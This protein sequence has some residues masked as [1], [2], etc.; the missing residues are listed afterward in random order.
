MALMGLSRVIAADPAAGRRWAAEPL[1][2]TERL[3]AVIA[4]LYGTLLESAQEA[5][6]LAAVADSPDLTAAAVPGG[7]A[8]ALAPAEKAGLIR[9]DSSGPHFTHPP[10]RPP[11]HHALPF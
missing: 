10:V 9:V 3:A 2:P 4:G 8:E 7:T 11:G 5:L 6:L 1:P